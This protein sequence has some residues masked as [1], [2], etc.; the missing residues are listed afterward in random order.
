[1]SIN[2]SK[3]VDPNSIPT[4]ILKLFINDVSSQLTELFNLSFSYEV[5]PLI[6]KTSKVIPAYKMC[7]NDSKLKCSNYRLIFLLSNTDKVLK[8]LMYNRLYKFLV[9][10]SVIYDLQFGFRQKY[11]T[12]HALIHLTDK[13]RE[14]LGSGNFVWWIFVDLQKAFD[15]VDL[16]IVIQKLY[17]YG[18]RGVANNWFSLYLQKKCQYVSINGFNSKLEHIHCGV[19]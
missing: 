14:Q 11:A 4:K 12:Y 3:A 5:F 16:D 15:K 17:N 9:M 6:L 10:N 19:P 8:R 2:P 1:M 18:I 13:I 7:S